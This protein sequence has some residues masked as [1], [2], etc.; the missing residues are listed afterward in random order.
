MLYYYHRECINV[1]GRAL[2]AEETTALL[3][4]LHQTSAL[5]FLKNLLMEEKRREKNHL[6]RLLGM[7]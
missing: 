2:R 7:T 3:G 6:D 1:E 5:A 4:E